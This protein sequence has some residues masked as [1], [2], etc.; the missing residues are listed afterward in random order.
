MFNKLNTPFKKIAF[1]VF[2]LLI[3][4]IIGLPAYG[5]FLLEFESRWTGRNLI[6]WEALKSFCGWEARRPGEDEFWFRIRSATSAFSAKMG[7]SFISFALLGV[8]YLL[9]RII[10]W[11]PNHGKRNDNA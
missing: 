9:V 2:C 10:F 4:F 8:F 3:L 11:S 7:A 6:N 5:D 1:G